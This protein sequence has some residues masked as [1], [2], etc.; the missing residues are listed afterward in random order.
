MKHVKMLGLAAVAA[1]ALMAFVGA[2][3]ASATELYSGATTL[4]SGTT[5][6]ASLSG[7]ASLLTT[8]RK[9]TL[10]TC[11]K[12]AVKGK[13][14]NTGS[15]TEAVKGNIESLTWEEC[16]EPTKTITVGTLQISWTSGQNGTL[17]AGTTAT[18]VT[19]ETTVFG[20]CVFT[21]GS[22][23]TIGTLTGSTTS[24][25]KLA[26][27]AIATRKSGLCPASA[28]WEGTYIVTNPKPLHVTAS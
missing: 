16:T 9:T 21:I 7:T 13:T 25:A 19:V 24:N 5:I 8:D 1:M 20:S 15:S 18:E 14:T 17:A 10:D 22:G 27:N 28:I 23:V 12:G 6:E 3:A 11:T 2:S 4:K 26:V